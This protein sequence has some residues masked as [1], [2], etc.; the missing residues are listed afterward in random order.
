M[1]RKAL[2]Q[3]SLLHTLDEYSVDNYGTN[4]LDEYRGDKTTSCMVS[5]SGYT[6]FGLS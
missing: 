2:H 5:S 1:E 6:S 3:S 4:T